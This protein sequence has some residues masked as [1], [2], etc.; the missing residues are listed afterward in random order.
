MH[1]FKIQEG[2]KK[3]KQN[4]HKMLIWFIIGTN[5]KPDFIAMSLPSLSITLLAYLFVSLLFNFPV[6]HLCCGFT[7]YITWL[8]WNNSTRKIQDAFTDNT[9]LPQCIKWN[10][11]GIESHLLH[12]PCH[13]YS[14]LGM[15]FAGLLSIKLITLN[16]IAFPLWVNRGHIFTSRLVS[17]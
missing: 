6:I 2:R 12:Y 13:W 10:I 14:Q 16:N 11:Q 9:I 5:K 7:C 3:G 1:I 8:T 15:F 4:I 17:K